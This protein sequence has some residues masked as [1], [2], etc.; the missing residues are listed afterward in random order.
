[1]PA[2]I[3]ADGMTASFDR[4]RQRFGAPLQAVGLLLVLSIAFFSTPLSRLGHTYYSSADL[5][6]DTA[7]THSQGGH[8]P[9]NPLLSDPAVQMQPWL[10]FNRDAFAAGEIPLWNDWNAAGAPHLANYQSAVFSPFSVPF[11]VLGFRWALLVSAFAKLFC[12]GLFAYLFFRAIELRQLAAIVGAVA[13]AFSGLNVLLL[14]YPHSAVAITL[15]AGLWC[16]E[17][18]IRSREEWLG[19]RAS[20]QS[21]PRRGRRWVFALG[22]V[23]V[24]GLLGGHPEPF[25]FALLLIGAYVITRLVGVWSRHRSDPAASA[26]LVWLAFEIALVGLLAAGVAA[27]QIVPFLEYL[28]HSTVLASRSQGQ[29]ALDIANWPLWFFPDVL[30]NPSAH[31]VLGYELPHP[32]YEDVNTAYAGAL[33]V[34]LAVLGAVFARSRRFLFF[35][36]CALVGVVYG[37]DL[38]GIGRLAGRNLLM[39]AAPMNRS[40]VF[41]VFGLCACAALCVDRMSAAAVLARWRTLVLAGA[42]ALALAL[43]A[44]LGAEHLFAQSVAKGPTLSP[45]EELEA[46]VAAH[47]VW[48][49]CSFGVGALA[50]L[51]MLRMHNAMGRRICAAVLVAAVFLESGFLLKDYNP[52]IEDETFFPRTQSIQDLQRTVKDRRLMVLGER[53]LPPDTNLPYALRIASNYDAL[54]VR[55]FDTLYKALFDSKDNW[56]TAERA[57]ETGLKLCGV[58]YVLTSAPWLAID[59]ET[60]GGDANQSGEVDGV[61]LAARRTL[62]QTFIAAKDRL[63]A[64]ELRVTRSATSGPRALRVVLEDL[65]TGTE[66]A[67]SDLDIPGGSLQE[68]QRAAAEMVSRPVI[69]RFAPIESSRGRS[70]RLTIRA[71]AGRPSDALLV[72][73]LRRRSAQSS[74]ETYEVDERPASGRLWFNRSYNLEAFEDVLRTSVYTLW[75][76]TKSP[77]RFYCVDGA[78]LA[79]T[80]DEALQRVLAP[81][82]DPA[83]VVILSAPAT[84]PLIQGAATASA[85]PATVIAD[86]HSYTRLRIE[87]TSPGYLVIS[88]SHYPGW[89]ARVNGVERPLLRANL[90][91]SAIQVEAGTSEI[92]LEYDPDSFTIGL[93]ISGLCALACAAW[94]ALAARRAAAPRASSAGV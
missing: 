42:A 94:M 37:Y 44:W 54:W 74:S 87:R 32:N 20:L 56:R 12:L 9:K 4:V 27:V 61:N 43:I 59:T 40:Q 68:S 31:R 26:P 76:Y 57:S 14:G 62:R 80:D 24:C 3:S 88:R 69:F 79:Q 67:A 81:D 29:P 51:A 48:I 45:V 83:R 10:M 49:A 39:S 93:W 25:C 92:E 89:R 21:P 90:G 1:M 36:A 71:A 23:L 63:Q 33:V 73:A 16:V 47:Y 6:Q 85:Q 52:T 19:W 66:V 86:T 64:I 7:L 60:D 38:L 17:K 13:F 82:F 65:S 5:S 91:V 11:Y 30:G 18:A 41:V 77:T 58:E 78:E 2:R 46:F 28:R 50:F 72:W 22:F 70:Y 55:E 53:C 75:R 35:A 34:W 8:R 84:T 15:P